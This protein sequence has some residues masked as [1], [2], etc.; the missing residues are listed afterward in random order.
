MRFVLGLIFLGLLGFV[1]YQF[2]LTYNTSNP[3]TS[4]RTLTPTLSQGDNTKLDLTTL[5]AV[6]GASI[7]S[8]L[9]TVEH[10][11]SD[12]TGG[13]SEPIINN[14]IHNFEQQLRQLP[15]DQVKKIQYNYC[16]SIV[17]EY[18]ANN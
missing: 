12:L 6:L 14:A 18:E 7:E 5:S 13:A 8:G 2:Y 17:D 4:H 9:T 3:A 11:L 15:E 16:K 10:T 1:G